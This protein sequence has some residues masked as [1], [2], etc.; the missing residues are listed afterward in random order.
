[1]TKIDKNIEI[2]TAVNNF[3]QQK[4]I[5]KNNLAKAIGINAATLCKTK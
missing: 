1:M 3:T 2:K 4:E 5:S